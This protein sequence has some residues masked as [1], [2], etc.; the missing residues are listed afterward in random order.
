L[1]LHDW[2]SSDEMREAE[3]PTFWFGVGGGV[4][5]Y[6]LTGQLEAAVKF[7]SN[8]VMGRHVGTTDIF[9]NMTETGVLYGRATRSLA[10]LG[11]V[12]VARGNRQHPLN[13]P[14]AG[15]EMPPTLGV[16]LH[17]QW[18]FGHWGPAG[19][20]LSGLANVNGEHSFAGLTLTIQ[21]GRF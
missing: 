4:G 21:I 8:V 15:P 14:G 11:G 2:A 7:G 19:L 20:A 5:G 18:R 3:T 13:E 1:I 16:A 17:G 10:F 6:G 12:G 9:A